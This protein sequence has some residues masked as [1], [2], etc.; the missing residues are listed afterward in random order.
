MIGIAEVA[1]VIVIL[2]VLLGLLYGLAFFFN[3]VTTR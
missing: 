2:A 3:W 1:L